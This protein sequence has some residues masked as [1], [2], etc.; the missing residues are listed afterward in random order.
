MI[1]DPKAT[2]VL[3]FG[4]EPDGNMEGIDGWWADER[5]E[6]TV[7]EPTFTIDQVNALTEK[8]RGL[9]PLV[10]AAYVRDGAIH[11]D[12]LFMAPKGVGLEANGP[13]AL[14][15]GRRALANGW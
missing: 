15:L 11:L 8:A 14:A 3:L 1:A 7:S 2:R 4:Y 9:R 6:P 5:K 13:G 10:T 12:L